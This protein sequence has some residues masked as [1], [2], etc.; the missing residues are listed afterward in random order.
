MSRTPRALLQLLAA[1]SLAACKDKNTPTLATKRTVLPDSADQVMMGLRHELLGDGI[2]R[3]ELHADTAYFYDRNTRIDMRV[4]NTRFFDRNGVQNATMTAKQGTYD[5]NA[6]K[7]DGRGDVVLTSSDGRKLT[8]PHVTYD[9]QLNQVSSDT[10]FTFT[11]P[12]STITGVGFRSDPQL[13]N[14]TV[15]S[16]VGGKTTL[17]GATAKRRARP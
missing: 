15:L 14:V 4:V 10:S 13:R 6:Q 9:R 3:G 2:R 11:A 17:G 5:T 12:G 7:L 8:S 16:Q 1:S